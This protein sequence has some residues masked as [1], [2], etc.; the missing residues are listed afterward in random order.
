MKI[1]SKCGGQIEKDEAKFCNFCGS[2]VENTQRT[3]CNTC[4]NEVANGVN[5]CTFC[6]Q[7]V[8]DMPSGVRQNNVF[9]PTAA[10]KSPLL[11]IISHVL[12]MLSVIMFFVG[13]GTLNPV[14]AVFM[15]FCSIGAIVTGAIG[16]KKSIRGLATAGMVIGIIMC[17][18]SVVAYIE[19][20]L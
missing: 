12:N 5:F 4:G 18:L 11:G 7:S 14:F 1:C 3:F 6:G 19:K 20:K 9:Q 8:Y 2:K 15:I 10:R 17:V 13:I 16:R